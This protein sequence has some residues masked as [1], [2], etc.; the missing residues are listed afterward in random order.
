MASQYSDLGK[1]AAGLLKDSFPFDPKTLAARTQFSLKASTK[2]AAANTA[3]N[4]S[5]ERIDDKPE[6]KIE[7]TFDHKECGLTL[8]E[9]FS[10]KD[11]TVTVTATV[12]DKIV[13]GSK[14]ALE[15]KLSR[16]GTQTAVVFNPSL[17]FAN[18]NFALRLKTELPLH[19]LSTDSKAELTGA[20]RRDKVQVGAQAKLHGVSLESYA[21]ILGYSVENSQ[22]TFGV[23]AKGG[24]TVTTSYFQRFCSSCD[25]RAAAE[26]KL[27]VSTLHPSIRASLLW[28]QNQD[29]TVGLFADSDLNLAASTKVKLNSN[30]T[31]SGSV[32]VPLAFS[33]SDNRVYGFGVDFSA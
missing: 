21:A 22:F 31:V 24:F 2:S 15:T 32:Y 27:P 20:F 30:V 9:A 29:T 6:S 23:E 10:T 5:F 14:V 19:K 26:V 28:N 11:S 1:S 16:A 4:T 33:S 25:G 7:V 18:D 8:K 3:V 12:A 13:A 17:D